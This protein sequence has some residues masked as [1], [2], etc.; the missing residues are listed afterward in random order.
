[1]TRHDLNPLLVC[2]AK[3]WQYFLATNLMCSPKSFYKKRRRIETSYRK[4]R[5]FLPK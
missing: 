4:I 2:D 5:E 1:M 3:S